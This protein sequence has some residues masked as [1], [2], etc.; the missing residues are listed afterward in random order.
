MLTAYADTEAAIKAINDV[1]LDY[2]LLKPWIHR[3]KMY[4]TLDDLLGEW[5]VGYRPKFEGIQVVGHRWS[6]DSHALK[7]F[8]GRNQI[9]FQWL[10]WKPIRKPHA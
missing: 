8:L 1:R 7:D 3:K 5:Q 10:D 2:Y 6:P 4:P 9:P